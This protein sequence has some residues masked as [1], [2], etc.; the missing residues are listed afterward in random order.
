MR[1]CVSLRS[2]R[3]A[4]N[5]AISLSRAAALR[6]VDFLLL[7]GELVARARPC[8]SAVAGIEPLAKLLGIHVRRIGLDLLLDLPQLGTKLV[9]LGVERLDLLLEVAELRGLGR[10]G[11]GGRGKLVAVKRLE[12]GEVLAP[13]LD[14][15]AELRLVLLDLLEDRL[16]GA[17]HGR[18]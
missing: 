2:S 17:S 1:V 5:C 4:R 16:I 7:F 8:T 3:F 10:L 14:L 9:L 18:A 13:L 12:G 6:L 15:G 11:N